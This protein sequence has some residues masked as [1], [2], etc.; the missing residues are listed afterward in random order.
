M[1]QND[2][3]LYEIK[4][5]VVISVLL[6]VAESFKWQGVI[7]LAGVETSYLTLVSVENIPLQKIAQY[8]NGTM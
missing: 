8:G 3:F 2:I 7:Y 1:K 5:N 4:Q 6:F